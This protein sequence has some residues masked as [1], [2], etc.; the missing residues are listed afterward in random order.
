MPDLHLPHWAGSNSLSESLI[1]K[2]EFPEYTIY[3]VDTSSISAVYDDI[4]L[5]EIEEDVSVLVRLTNYRHQRNVSADAFFTLSPDEFVADSGYSEDRLTTYR[6]V[7]VGEKRQNDGEIC[8]LCGEDVSSRQFVYR[9]TGG[10]TS[11]VSHATCWTGLL[12]HVEEVI[13]QNSDLLTLHSI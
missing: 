11:A 7:G 4:T 6:G 8:H 2:E 9:F 12:Q 3:L 5:R 1:T 10:E 13:Y